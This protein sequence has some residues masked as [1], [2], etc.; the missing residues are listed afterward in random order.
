M[1]PQLHLQ[2]PNHDFAVAYSLAGPNLAA[3]SRPCPCSGSALC[4]SPDVNCYG[5]QNS[6]CSSLGGKHVPSVV[7]DAATAR[8]SWRHFAAGQLLA[9]PEGA[10]VRTCRAGTMTRDIC[11]KQPAHVCS[12]DGL[13]S[14]DANGYT[15]QLRPAWSDERG[16]AM[17]LST[18]V[19][20]HAVFERCDRCIFW[21]S[22]NAAQCLL[23]PNTWQY[24]ELGAICGSTHVECQLDVHRGL[25][26]NANK[27]G[28]A[29]RPLLCR[30]LLFA[31]D[32]TQEARRNVC[33]VLCP[34]IHADAV[35]LVTMNIILYLSLV[36]TAVA[37]PWRMPASNV[38]DMWL[39]VGLLV[40]MDMAS[41]FAAQEVDAF[42]S[43]IISML[44]LSFMAVGIL[45]V[46]L[47]GIVLQVA[48]SRRKPWRFFLS[49]HKFAA[50][51][52]ARLLKIHLQKRSV[53]FTTFLDT[54]NLRD[55]TELFSFVRASETVVVL[56]SAG[57]LA[58]KWCIG[59]IVSA[60]L[61]K[62]HTLVLKWPTFIY[63]NEL[64]C[65]NLTV[66]IPGVEVLTAH[67]ISLNDVA[68][69]M[70]WLRAADAISVPDLLDAESISRICDS[71]TGMMPRVSTSRERSKNPKETS[72]MQANCLILADPRNQEAVATSYILVELLVALLKGD[73]LPIV[74]Q[75]KESMPENSGRQWQVLLVCS[76]GC[77]KSSDL[78][79]WLI[80]LYHDLAPVILPIA[81]SEFVVPLAPYEDAA[82][83][84]ETPLTDHEHNIYCSMIGLV[85]Q[86]IAIV[87]APQSSTQE[88]LELRVKQIALRLQAKSSRPRTTSMRSVQTPRSPASPKSP[89][90]AGPGQAKDEGE[91]LEDDF[92]SF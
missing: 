82:S 33:I 69:A 2:F 9:L 83:S 79:Y 56:A 54:D 41:V 75:G 78:A 45:L 23:L 73:V 86:E 67:G 87:F 84:V 90:A 61:H 43:A 66:A 62:I 14:L 26:A 34:L 6:N 8:L 29:M 60:R 48:R 88:D 1:L 63:P 46:I 20:G 25:P 68:D 38:L 71:L 55:L 80:D 27:G 89:L 91:L 85:F 22:P 49:H 58:R 18:V 47:H 10:T 40:V 30:A 72:P 32:R 12:H 57:I 13:Y 24:R 37:Q 31:A 52:F 16:C 35:Q 77:F 76:S 5:F 53:H 92:F 21:F 59:E 17:R 65:K 11:R 4:S 42:I 44:F 81:G 28:C 64:F 19:N 36:A 74:L 51:A 70:T 39:H 15:V 7:G 3:D 50:G